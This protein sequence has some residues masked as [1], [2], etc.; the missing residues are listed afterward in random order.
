MGCWMRVLGQEE[1]IVR[2]SEWLNR[3]F[4]LQRIPGMLLWYR[5][6]Y[7]TIVIVLT[8]IAGMPIFGLSAQAAVTYTP[9]QVLKKIEASRAQISN[10]TFECV[11]KTYM[12]SIKAP[13]GKTFGG[14]PEW[15]KQTFY[16]DDLGR[17]RCISQRGPMTEDG[18]MLEAEEHLVEEMTYDGAIVVSSKL[19]PNLAR[20]GRK[21]KS[22][23]NATGYNSVIICDG[24]APL[25]KGLESE[26]N[27]F[28]YMSN[29]ALP[30]IQ[31]AIN[32]QS[33]IV[34]TSSQNGRVL[35]TIKHTEPGSSYATSVI[36]V[37]PEHNWTIESIKSYRSDGGLSREIACDYKEQADGLWVPIRGRHT[38]WGNRDQS[39]KP[40]FDWRFETSKAVFNDPSFDQRIFEI[41]LKP[42]ASVADTRYE[43]SYRVGNEEAVAADLA[44]YATD[45]R[46]EAE[47]S[48]QPKAHGELRRLEPS[49]SRKIVL[50]V[51]TVLLIGCVCIFVMRRI[52][53][54]AR[55]SS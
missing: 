36:T 22:A 24:E 49:W 33:V 43:V 51:T 45:A 38:H 15:Q 31:A 20:D 26:R 13:N 52:R 29:I 28:E 11:W 3:A 18:K 34:D 48:K 4:L 44:R 14:T 32:R 46:K 47:K 25:R 50:V 41:R 6:Q 21:P 5:R 30:E 37:V 9:Q 17:R 23:E 42:D 40:H 54:R 27:P 16:W 53:R 10:A 2:Q 1:Y 8:F 7:M 12:E 55:Y 19:Y 39:A 35:L